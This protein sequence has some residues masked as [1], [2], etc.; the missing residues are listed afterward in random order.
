MTLPN[1]GKSLSFYDSLF[2]KG[3]SGIVRHYFFSLRNCPDGVS[4]V[5]APTV[6]KFLKAEHARAVRICRQARMLKF[7]GLR[8]TDTN[9]WLDGYEAAC[10]DILTALQRGR[11]GKG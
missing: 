3:S 7:H 9:E 2:I 1:C 10:N 11:G 8:D 4:V 6:E 5:Y